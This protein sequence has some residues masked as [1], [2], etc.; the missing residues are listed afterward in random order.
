[1]VVMEKKYLSP[2]MLGAPKQIMEW[3][4]LNL[5]LGLLGKLF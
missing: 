3:V 4:Q 2:P 5:D 1:M